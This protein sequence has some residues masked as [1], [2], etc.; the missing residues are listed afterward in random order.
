MGG[1]CVINNAA[2]AAQVLRDDTFEGDPISGCKLRSADYLQFGRAI[3]QW[4]LPTVL[5]FEG[6]C[7]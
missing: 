3:P 6:R 1:Y 2:V 4:G 5:T 7:L